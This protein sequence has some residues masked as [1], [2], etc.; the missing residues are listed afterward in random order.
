MTR[1]EQP[2]EHEKVDVDE[3]EEWD[4][5][6]HFQKPQRSNSCQQNLTFGNRKTRRRE[7]EKTT[8]VSFFRLFLRPKYFGPDAADADADADAEAE[9]VES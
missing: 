7:A 9:N 3:S 4:E 5:H 1:L 8:T 6:G 2:D